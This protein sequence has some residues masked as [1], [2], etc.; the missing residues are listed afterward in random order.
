MRSWRVAAMPS[1]VCKAAVLA[2]AAMVLGACSSGPKIVPNELRS[3]S[4]TRAL[5]IDWTAS[6][7]EAG[8]RPAVRLSPF[9]G[10]DRVFTVNAR[11]RVIAMDIAS[12]KRVWTRDIG[13]AITAGVSGDPER[14]YVASEDGE[15]FAIE[16]SDGAIAWTA[17]VSSEV[18]AAPVAG[19]GSVLVRSIDGRVV[20]LERASG[21][22]RWVYS[23]N[24]PAL[25]LHGNS[26]ALAVP[27]GYLVGLDNGRLVALRAR[28]G[29]VFWELNLAGGT[30]RS[31][32]DKLNDLDAD[33]KLYDDRIYAVS[34]QGK[35]AQVDPSRGVT[36]WTAPMSS[37][38]GFSL[39]AE[40][41]YVTDEFD[42]VW[43]LSR[44]DGKVL[45][46]QESFTNRR[47]TAP[48]VGGDVVLVGDF[49]GYVHLLSAADGEIVGRRKVGGAEIMTSPVNRDE[50]F[51]IQDRGGR[52][53]R[54]S[55]K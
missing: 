23:Y 16:Q 12:G 26:R 38:V 41:I 42:T 40:R 5:N 35:M 14:L 43:A 46:Q 47:L 24:V 6:V 50:G 21:E 18:I 29:R 44:A 31:E 25:S 33:I 53:A 15:V 27:D 36:E 17:N 28:D 11:G 37:A 7:G 4:A 34:Y 3:I 13:E 22:R 45:W 49:E 10:E 48:A 55:V 54:I 32:V 19:A 8:E 1:R 39:D 51:F 9:I 30:G 20:A 2:L 52:L